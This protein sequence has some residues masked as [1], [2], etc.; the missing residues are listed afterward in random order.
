MGQRESSYRAYRFMALR[1][2]ALGCLLLLTPVVLWSAVLG[3]SALVVA[4]SWMGTVGARS[5][6]AWA[7]ARSPGL[8]RS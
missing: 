7:A 1:I 8:P 5:A 3:M 2:N 6:S 4:V